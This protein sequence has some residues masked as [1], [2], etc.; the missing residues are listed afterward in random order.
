[1]SPTAFLLA[2]SALVAIKTVTRIGVDTA[3][4]DD[5]PRPSQID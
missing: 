4:F 1:M 5:L 3:R 2:L